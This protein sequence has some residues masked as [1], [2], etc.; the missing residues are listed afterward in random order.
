MVVEVMVVVVVVVVCWLDAGR[1]L[2]WHV[3]GVSGYLSGVAKLPSEQ[4]Y[5]QPRYP[6]VTVG[7]ATRCAASLFAPRREA[8][9][10]AIASRSFTRQAPPPSAAANL[11][12]SISSLRQALRPGRPSSARQPVA[13][14]Q[15]R[16]EIVRQPRECYG[17]LRTLERG[18]L[19]VRG[20]KE[21]SHQG[22]HHYHSSSRATLL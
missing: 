15:W 12:S 22:L 9:N 2:L 19:S 20:E 16:A 6:H 4:R 11:F 8:T 18:G 7:S 14:I 13:R 10:T 5:G 17:A 3:A 1:S 21:R